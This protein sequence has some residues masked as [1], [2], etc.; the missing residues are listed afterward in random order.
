[1]Q[2]DPLKRVWVIDRQHWPRALL[3]GELLESGFEVAGFESLEDALAA[4]ER[5]TAFWP[6]LIVIELK[7]LGVAVEAGLS[8]L[9]YIDL[10]IILMGGAVELNKEVVRSGKWTAIL[11][12]PF[13]LGRVVC[14]VSEQLQA[15][16]GN[17]G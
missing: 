15:A 5:V 9:A 16:G 17:P 4:L 11:K 13:T 14:L 2:V 12:R 6:D 1:M 8:H 10:P 3:C 7:G